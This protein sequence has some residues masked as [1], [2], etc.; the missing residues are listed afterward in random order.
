[1]TSVGVTSFGVGYT[2]APAVTISAPL[3]GGVTATGTAN[4][5][6]PCPCGTVAG[7][8]VTNGGSGYGIPDPGRPVSFSG[9]GGSGAAGIISGVGGGTVSSV[10]VTVGGSGYTSPPTVAISAPVGGGVTATGVSFV[11]PCAVPTF[12]PAPLLLC[13]ILLAAGGAFFLGR[14]ATGVRPGLGG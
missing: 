3:G 7:V 13:A 11:G 12:S 4:V 8:A 5:S 6:G 10:A 14:A 9:G 2:S 1:V